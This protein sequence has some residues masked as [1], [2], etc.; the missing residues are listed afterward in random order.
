MLSATRNQI[1]AKIRFS[2][3]NTKS[4]LCMLNHHFRELHTNGTK[5]SPKMERKIWSTDPG[6][7]FRIVIQARR[8]IVQDKHP[9]SFTSSA[10]HPSE[11]LVISLSSARCRSRVANIYQSS[12]GGEYIS[13][14]ICS[15]VIRE[16]QTD[17]IMF[18]HTALPTVLLSSHHKLHSGT[19]VNAHK[20]P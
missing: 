5:T 12:W 9:H 10:L 1:G 7:S 3:K 2:T 15:N 17:K 8:H 13:V 14:P 18:I 4:E 16:N 6:R 19:H 20:C 11:I